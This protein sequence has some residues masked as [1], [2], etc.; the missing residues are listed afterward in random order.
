MYGLIA[1][2]ISEAGQREALAAVLL[3]GMRDLPGCLSYVVARD[4]GDADALWVTE[5]WRSNDAHRASL[6][7]PA[8]LDA[9][10]RGRPL[11]RDFEVRV[12]T[13]PVGG[14]GL[15]GEGRGS[16]DGSVPADAEG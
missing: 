14:H 2:I 6:E 3:A 7:R 5:V 9:I 13:E 10:A 11:I 1:K 16:A 15:A 4:P 12:E 8:V